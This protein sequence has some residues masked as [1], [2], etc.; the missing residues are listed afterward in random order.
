VVWSN[1]ACPVELG[2]VDRAGLSAGGSKRDLMK[3]ELKKLKRQGNGACWVAHA[4]GEVRKEGL[5][6]GPR[7]GCMNPGVKA[8]GV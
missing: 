8:H 7:G 6:G 5:R 4:M 1:W 2:N 3:G